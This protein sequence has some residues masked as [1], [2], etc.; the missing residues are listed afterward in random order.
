MDVQG[1]LQE[2]FS[3]WMHFAD[4]QVQVAFVPLDEVNRIQSEA[5]ATTIIEGRVI[6]ELD[7]V[8]Y[9]ELLADAAVRDWKGLRNGD[10]DF[11]YS[12]EHAR[13]LMRKW[14]AF[15]KFVTDACVSLMRL[16]REAKREAVKN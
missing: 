4:F 10:E 12:R 5:T 11:P 7:N 8:K 2:G 13:L 15:H 14:G 3:A 9:A 16:T 1:L 6:Q